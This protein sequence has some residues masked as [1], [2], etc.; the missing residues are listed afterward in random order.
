MAASLRV[1]PPRRE[2]NGITP[3]TCEVSVV[4]PCLNEA[5]TIAGCVGKAVET[6]E[7][8]G[9]SGEVIVADNGSV[10]GSVALAEKAGARVVQVVERGYG[11]ALRGGIAQARGR[12]VIMGDGDGSYD[13]AAIPVFLE[14]LRQGFEL[15]MGNRFSGGIQPGA[16]PWKNRWL[17]NPALSG[18]GRFLFGI[19]V[20]DFHCGLRGIARVAFENLGLRTTG[21]EFASEMVIKA[22]LHGMKMAEV[23]ATLAPDGR[24]RPPHL[25]PWRDG[26]RHLRFMLLFSPRWLFLVPGFVLLAV[27]AAATVTLVRGPVKLAGLTLDIHSLLVA[28]FL[29]VLGYQLV[30]F[31]VFARVYAS[32]EGFVGPQRLLSRASR[33]LNLE[34]GLALGSGGFLVG[35]ALA[36]VAVIEWRAT[37]FAALN[38]V[39]T[40]RRLIPAVLLMI[41]GAQTIFSSFFVSILTL[42]KRGPTD[43]ASQD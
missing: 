32:A 6:L 12:F 20:R 2:R 37:G 14:K 3:A 42:A 16:M 23:P 7:R 1:S 31:G 29:C 26:W 5:E 17:G 34:L 8:E 36:A 18:L 4:I 24:S 15:V 33:Y 41:L 40:M 25:R 9:I 19:S 11:S 13:F 28:A 10:D 21:M 30:I 35:L 38:P 27:G 39:V 22:H 43:G